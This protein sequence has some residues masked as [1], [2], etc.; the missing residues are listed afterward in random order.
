MAVLSA[1]AAWRSPAAGSTGCTARRCPAAPTSATTRTPHDLLRRRARPRAAVGGQGQRRRGRQGRPAITLR[2]VGDAKVTVQGQRATSTCRR[3]RAPRC[4]QTSLLGE[5]Y[6]AL[7]QPLGDAVDGHADQRRDHP[8]DRAPVGAR[9]RGGARR[10]VAAAQ[11]GRPAADPDHRDRAEQGARRATRA[12][13]ATC[14]ASSTPSSARSTTRRTRSPPRWTAST[15]SRVTLN[16][17]K[18]SLTDALDTFPQRAEGARRRARQARR[19]ADQPVQPRH[20]RHPR[21][22][23]D[24]DTTLTSVAEVADAGR[25]SSSPRPG[26]TCP[27]R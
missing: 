11:R 7:E 18:R 13:S 17:Q 22:Q 14:S 25:W 15:R 1:V 5:K 27:R 9:G 24:P 8:A 23:R 19:P 10:A 2:R 26:P 20:R 4:K 21:H 16:R 12:R 3:T 6:V